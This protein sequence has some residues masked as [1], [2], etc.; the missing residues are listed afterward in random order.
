M[1]KKFFV[2]GL[3]LHMVLFVDAMDTEKKVKKE[4]KQIKTAVFAKK[5]DVYKELFKAQY[6]QMSDEAVKALARQFDDSWY[7]AECIRFW[8]GIPSKMVV[9]INNTEY[10]I[11]SKYLSNLMLESRKMVKEEK[12]L[13]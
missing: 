7:E 12:A 9:N 6:P 5:G 4:W 1:I 13:N 11:A 2:F 8:E 3:A 10:G